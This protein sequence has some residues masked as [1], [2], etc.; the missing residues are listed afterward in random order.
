[1]LV[2]LIAFSFCLKLS[3][4]YYRNDIRVAE[5][6][7]GEKSKRGERQRVLHLHLHI[8]MDTYIK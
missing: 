2:G 5:Q 7:V 1:M 4:I 8:Y 3:V 6:I